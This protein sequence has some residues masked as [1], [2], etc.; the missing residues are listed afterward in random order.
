MKDRWERGIALHF[1]PA[2]AFGAPTTI[3]LAEARRSA[4]LLPLY[5]TGAELHFNIDGVLAAGEGSRSTLYRSGIVEAASAQ[6]IDRDVIPSY[7]LALNCV[8]ALDRYRRLCRKLEISAPIFVLATLFG[9]RD[10][11]FAV[12]AERWTGD[13][14]TPMF[15][16]DDVSLPDVVLENLDTPATLTLRPMFDAL[17][18]AVGSAGTDLYD[19]DGSWKKR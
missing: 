4:L 18:Q 1:I 15:D 10:R 12:S 7:A 2:S 13:Y 17:W 8:E 19:A 3:D 5:P 6:L 11:K 14:Y 16:R 9:V